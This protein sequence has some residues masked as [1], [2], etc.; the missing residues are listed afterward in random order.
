MTGLV[1]AAALDR[2]D[3]EQLTGVV[4]R[5]GSAQAHRGDERQGIVTLG[6]LSFEVA[7]LSLCKGEDNNHQPAH[8]PDRQLW[9]AIDGKIFNR[10]EVERGL[11]DLTRPIGKW[12]DAES[13]SGGLQGMG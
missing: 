11:A 4:E 2:S 6:P 8:D 12:N 9:A 7:P 13:G 3:G 1:G 5:M 10:G